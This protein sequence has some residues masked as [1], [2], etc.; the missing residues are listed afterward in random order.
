MGVK[1]QSAVEFITTYGTSLLII[2]LMLAVLFFFLSIPARLIPTQCTISSGINCTFAQYGS[3]A[4]TPNSQL[5]VVGTDSQPGVLNISS[6]GASLNGVH[7]ISGFCTPNSIT[8]GEVVYCAASFNF[9]GVPSGSYTGQFAIA[10]NYCSSGVQNVSTV[11]CN[12]A[13]TYTIRGSILLDAATHVQQVNT[14]VYA[15]ITLTNTQSSTVAAGVQQKISFIPAAY[16]AYENSN[17][18]NIRFYYNGKELNSWCET[19]CTNTSVSNA[20]F[21]VKLPVPIGASGTA[22]STINIVMY[23]LPTFVNYDS[24]YAGEAPQM[25]PLYAEYDNG[26]SVFNYYDNFAGSTLSQSYTQIVPAG[27]T[28][29]QNNGITIATSGAGYGGIIYNPAFGNQTV[30]E[31]DVN[32]IAGS[33]AGFM[34][35]NINTSVGTG[36][37]LISSSQSG[38]AGSMQSGL[39]G[40]FSNLQ[41]TAGVMGGA[42]YSSSAQQWFNNYASTI[43]TSAT[44]QLPYQEYLS[45]G[46]YAAS[47][48]SSIRLQWAR[49]RAY[50]S[51][52]IMPS[53]TINPLA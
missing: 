48:S 23:F 14:P 25:S 8:Q 28:I 27:T 52:G 49:A 41:I 34:I 3:I 24:V 35:Q 31:V 16:S 12:A 22:R 30:F 18:G 15:P 47:S 4:N 33:G 40:G 43:E 7:S 44:Y 51:N 42:W 39:S 13:T 36:Y 17:L 53:F 11:N 9:A 10:A 6:F 21:W 29:V 19:A 20:I 1:A 38:G 32:S 50:T 26:A 2:A 45:V 46:A 5:I 37:G